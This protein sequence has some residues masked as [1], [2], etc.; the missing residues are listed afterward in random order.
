MKNYSSTYYSPIANIREYY[1]EEG[2]FHRLDG[3][4]IDDDD[5]KSEIHYYYFHGEEIKVSSQKEFEKYLKMK[6]FW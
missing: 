2:R 5:P 3:P 1:D 6:A 4:A